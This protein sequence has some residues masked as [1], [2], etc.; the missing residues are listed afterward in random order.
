MRRHLAVALLAA[1]GLGNQAGADEDAIW[2]TAAAIDVHAHLGTFQGYDLSLET[3]LANMDRHGIRI[4]L[5]SNID[6]AALPG[7]T[8][9]L[10][11]VPANAATREVVAKHPRLRGLAWARP[12]EPSS[13]PANLRPFLEK[14]RFVGVKLHPEMNRFAADAAVVDGYMQLCARWGVPAV[15]HCQS[16]GPIARLA[17]R[18]ATVPVILYHSGLAS[19]HEEAIRTVDEALKARDCDLYLETAQVQ[20]DKALEMV[21]RVGASRVVFGTD[22][23]YYGAEHYRNYTPLVSLL[24]E[25]LAPADFRLVMSGNAERLFKLPAGER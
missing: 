25:K 15:V 12:G 13:S 17:R 9:D 7:T 4:A 11:E 21:R 16:A 22:A 14:D 5:V 23:T 3:L 6:G 10:P 18:H 8:G 19:D 2:R 1:L 20:A 24:A